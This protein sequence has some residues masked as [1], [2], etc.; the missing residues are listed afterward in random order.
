MVGGV[1]SAVW[2]AVRRVGSRGEVGVRGM[3]MGVVELAAIGGDG[4]RSLVMG[5][6]KG[7]RWIYGTGKIVDLRGASL[8]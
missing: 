4:L 7:W 2:R 8:S 5:E 3:R 1:R 6:W